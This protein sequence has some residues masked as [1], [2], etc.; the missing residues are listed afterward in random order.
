M[1]VRPTRTDALTLRRYNVARMVS[2]P[3]KGKPTHD[4]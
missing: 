1:T 3:Q 2:L 4:C